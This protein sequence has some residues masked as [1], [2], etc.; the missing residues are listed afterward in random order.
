VMNRGLLQQVATPGDLYEYPTSRFV[1]EFIGQVNMFEGRLEIDEPSHAV[2]DAVGLPAPVYID[3]GV[4]GATASTVWVALRPEKIE[5]RKRADGQ[6]APPLDDAPPGHNIVA[7]VVRQ[8]TYLGAV[9]LYE[10]EL[11]NGRRLK[12]LR[13]NL[14]RQDQED[15]VLDEPVWLAWRACSPAVLQS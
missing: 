13:S 9:S 10:V 4:T 1:A 11:A 2:V 3:H 5:L 14:T 15:F 6:A 8:I 7:G 12:T